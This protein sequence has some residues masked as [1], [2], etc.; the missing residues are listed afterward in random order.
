MF[1]FDCAWS[2]LLRWHFSSCHERGVFLAVHGLLIA[3]L[4]LWSIG[5]KVPASVVVARRLSSYSSLV[6]QQDIWTSFQ[7]PELGLKTLQQTYEDLQHPDLLS[8]G[9]V[10]SPIKRRACTLIVSLLFATES[11][12]PI[13]RIRKSV[14]S[15]PTFLDLG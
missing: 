7:R 1:I 9:L 4:L 6:L 12:L 5:S 15:G 10:P 2:P 14:S 3:C 8:V 13:T 11:Q